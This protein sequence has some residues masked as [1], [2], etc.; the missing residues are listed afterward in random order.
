MT[1][2]SPS[3]G[4]HAR[5]SRGPVRVLAEPD[6]GD[7]TVAALHEFLADVAEVAEQNGVDPGGLRPWAAVRR[8]GTVKAIGVTVPGRRA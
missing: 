2:L 1:L 4:K 8:S 5:S 3:R 6:A 7:L